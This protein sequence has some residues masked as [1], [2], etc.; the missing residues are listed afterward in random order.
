M[1]HL[2]KDS[3]A[4]RHAQS[5]QAALQEWKDAVAY[6]ESV[7]DPELIDFAAYGIETAK[8][9]YMFL[10]KRGRGGTN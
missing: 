6:F 4:D 1:F 10:L 7:R 2:T 5:V 3:T 8:R 9:K